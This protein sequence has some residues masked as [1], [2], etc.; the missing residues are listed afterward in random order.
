MNEDLE[1]IEVER[2]QAHPRSGGLKGGEKEL[3][4]CGG[5]GSQRKEN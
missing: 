2:G 3:T 4:V 5:G 1:E